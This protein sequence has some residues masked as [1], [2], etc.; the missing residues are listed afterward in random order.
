[1]TERDRQNPGPTIEKGI[2]QLFASFPG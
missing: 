2:A 1:V